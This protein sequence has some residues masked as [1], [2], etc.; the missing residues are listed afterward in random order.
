MTSSMGLRHHAIA[1]FSF[2]LSL[3]PTRRVAFA[4]S[5]E[6]KPHGP[7]L[8]DHIDAALLTNWHE[9]HG[10]HLASLSSISPSLLMICQHGE[11]D[12]LGVTISFSL[13]GL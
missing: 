2:A 7:V 11:S 8:R 10:T 13:H 12:F 4:Y 6:G 3:A 9:D 1:A 5:Q